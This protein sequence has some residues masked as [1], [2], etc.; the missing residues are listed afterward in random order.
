MITPRDQ[1]VG[2]VLRLVTAQ[3][4]LKFHDRRPFL[5]LL[6][7]RFIFKGFPLSI[8]NIRNISGFS[9]G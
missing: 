2:C 7:P 6:P 4:A 1:R 8:R 9:R 3:A 5:E